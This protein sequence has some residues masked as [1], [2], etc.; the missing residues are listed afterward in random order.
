MLETIILNTLDFY[1]FMRWPKYIYIVNRQTN[2]NDHTIST[3]I[4]EHTGKDEGYRNV[5]VACQIWN[6]T[7]MSN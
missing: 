4:V 3:S 1:H 5:N 2:K 6:T 7:S